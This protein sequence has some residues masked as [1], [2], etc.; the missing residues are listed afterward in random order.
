MLCVVIINT[1]WQL[2]VAVSPNGK[3][4]VVATDKD[5][6]I[7]YSRASGK[8]LKNL[9]VMNPYIWDGPQ[10]DSAASIF[11]LQALACQSANLRSCGWFKPT[12]AK[13][14]LP[15]TEQ[16]TTVSPTLGSAFTRLV[17]HS[18]CWWLCTLSAG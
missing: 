16:T 3:F 6:V 18:S 5:R 14:C 1:K 15:G 12:N 13:Q 8:L 4:V 11:W 10:I 9:Q 2:Q 7:F 17:S